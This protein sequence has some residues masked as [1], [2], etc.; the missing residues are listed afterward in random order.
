MEGPDRALYISLGL[1]PPKA[2]RLIELVGRFRQFGYGLVIIDWGGL[3]PW[4]EKRFQCAQ[5]YPEHAVVEVHSRAADSGLTLI[6]RLP[7]GGG[8]STFLSPPGYR[9]LRLCGCDPD[10]IDPSSPGSAKFVSELLED[11]RAL[12]TD[13]SG[14]Y[15]DPMHYGNPVDGYRKDFCEVFIPRVLEEAGGFPIIVPPFL[16]EAV[17]DHETSR[18]LPRDP[19]RFFGAKKGNL[20][21]TLEIYLDLMPGPQADGFSSE[22]SEMVR[23]AELRA[24]FEMFI[25]NVASCWELIRNV[26]EDA[27]F[28][29]CTGYSPQR[30]Q[31]LYQNAVGELESAVKRM[32]DLI[33]NAAAP[34]RSCIVPDV[35]RRWGR[36]R[37]DPVVEQISQ[38][39]ALSRQVDSWIETR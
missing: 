35:L 34:L 25:R 6:P 9:S 2:E 27:S 22:D 16:A 26:R 20:P 15:I 3:F 31:V 14:V 8:M 23:S 10:F 18:A 19:E 39:R 11:M 37:I 12:L 4:S 7:A 13:L 28:P 24:L 33:D 17:C 38:L 5:A 29:P 36:S 21:P 32:D 30:S 1:F